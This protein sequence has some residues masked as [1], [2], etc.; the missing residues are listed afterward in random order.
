[1]KKLEEEMKKVLW[2]CEKTNDS[3]FK[4]ESQLNRSIFFMNALMH[5]IYGINLD[6]IFQKM[7]HY[8][9]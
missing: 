9:F 3:Q 5:K 8:Q 4:G 1:M 7:L 6:Y 2:V